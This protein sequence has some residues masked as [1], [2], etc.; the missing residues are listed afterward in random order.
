MPLALAQGVPGW[1]EGWPR[2]G[3]RPG[4]GDPWE[5]AAAVQVGR[6]CVWEEHHRR[7]GCDSRKPRPGSSLPLLA[8][9][10]LGRES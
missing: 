10:G 5:V 3:S 1:R 2:A 4:P 6:P 9:A 7:T 8:T